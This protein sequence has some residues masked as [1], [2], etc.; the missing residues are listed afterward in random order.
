MYLIFFERNKIIVNLRHYDT[1]TITDTLKWKFLRVLH[2]KKTIEL[3][4]GHFLGRVKTI[5]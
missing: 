1:V 3:V 2:K 4:V 5:E